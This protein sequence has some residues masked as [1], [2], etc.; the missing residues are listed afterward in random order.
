MR[1]RSALAVTLLAALAL[2]GCSDDGQSGEDGTPTD[3][4]SS[5]TSTP[6]AVGPASTGNELADRL[7]EALTREGSYRATGNN[8]Q[9][10]AAVEAQAQFKG[11]KLS[12]HIAFDEQTQITRIEGEGA[13]YTDETGKW[14]TGD[15]SAD[16]DDA[17]FLY[18]QRS[19]IAGLTAIPTMN[20]LGTE[21][22]NGVTATHYQGGTD[23]EAY[24]K[25][26]TP[27]SD[28][29]QTTGGDVAVD[30]WVDDKDRIVRFDYLL[31]PGEDFTDAISPQVQRTDYSGFGDDVSIKKPDL[32]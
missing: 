2:A 30:V 27:P 3:T 19:Q 5:S 21:E 28:I 7:N 16:L 8:P 13:W 23:A 6:G 18:D 15:E 22:V 9:P 25:A 24:G 29:L 31:I 20:D 11:D 12:I 14:T 1:L 10:G 26:L 17:V 4:A 32:G